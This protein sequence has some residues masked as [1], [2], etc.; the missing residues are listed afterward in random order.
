MQVTQQFKTATM[1][2][3]ED[4][5]LS[6]PVVVGIVGG[7]HDE[8]ELLQLKLMGM[9][10]TVTTLGIEGS[11][12]FFDL[13]SE[14]D[15]NDNSIKFDLILCSQV[16]EHIWN[17]QTFFENLRKILAT[18]GFLWLA[19]PAANRPHG[20]PEYFSAGFTD[21]YLAKNLTNSGF[22]V[23][24]QGTIGSKRLYVSTL[25]FDKWL[26]VSEHQHP[27]MEIAR[28]KSAGFRAIDPRR[29]IRLIQISLI[30]KTCQSQIRFAT[31][32][33]CFAKKI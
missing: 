21:E 23:I 27:I 31:E 6:S 1:R 26:T 22:R 3:F 5:K 25:I 16:L 20:S 32:S 11:D 19:A 8:P 28:F 13:N 12:V 18:N 7:S 10:F 9:E 17:H 14:F 29:I 4:L 24:S 30:S 2:E 33:W 15:E